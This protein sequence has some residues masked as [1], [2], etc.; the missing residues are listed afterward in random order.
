MMIF[1]RISRNTPRYIWIFL[2]ALCQVLLLFILLHGKIEPLPPEVQNMDRDDESSPEIAT[3]T[4]IPLPTPLTGNL[5]DIA[6]VIN[7][8]T[9]CWGNPKTIVFIITRVHNYRQR[10]VI[11]A[12]WAKPTSDIRFAFLVGL[13]DATDHL[14]D[15]F[16][17]AEMT[18]YGDII[19]LGVE[20]TYDR[21]TI[22]TGG[23]IKWVYDYCRHV[24]YVIKSDDD[25]YLDAAQFTSALDAHADQNAYFVCKV[26]FRP[27]VNRD[28]TSKFFVG[29]ESWPLSTFPNHCCGSGY[30]FTANIIPDMW[31]TALKTDLMKNEDVWWTG[32]V[33]MKINGVKLISDERIHFTPSLKNWCEVKPYI[34][35]HELQPENMLEIWREKLAG[36]TCPPPK[37][38]RS[39]NKPK[40][41]DE[42][43]QKH[44]SLTGKGVS[45]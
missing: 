21:L 39:T 8:T 41:T 11:R 10:R 3:A 15:W 4:E 9:I 33:G 37:R 40:I 18:T 20:D 14:W 7:N 17:F 19:Q 38:P 44:K 13:P 5:R 42:E 31:G 2:A 43:A 36:K 23:M 16:L 22:K 27:K 34:T 30:G 12:T 6:F 45:R 29:R 32:I 26:F 1:L 28:P 25:M 35:T 24:K